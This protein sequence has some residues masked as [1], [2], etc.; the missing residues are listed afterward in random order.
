MPFGDQQSCPADTEIL[1]L[2]TPKAVFRHDDVAP[3]P[4]VIIEETGN[5]CR[6]ARRQ[7]LWKACP[8]VR[9]EMLR[10]LRP[11]VGA[12]ASLEIDGVDLGRFARYSHAFSFPTCIDFDTFWNCRALRFL[13]SNPA[14]TTSVTARGAEAQVHLWTT[15]GIAVAFPPD[16]SR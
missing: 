1:V 5:R 3:E 6:F 4:A 11:V 12:H 7:E 10:D 8:A 16:D 2:S 13:P 9:V 15:A 14:H